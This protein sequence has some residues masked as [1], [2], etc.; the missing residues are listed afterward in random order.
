MNA[1][2]LGNKRRL[3]LNTPQKM[4][5]TMKSYADCLDRSVQRAER[6]LKITGG[7]NFSAQFSP[8]IEL[9]WK[10]DNA[11]ISLAYIDA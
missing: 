5:Q 2:C 8:N 10:V 9:V 6:T 3:E 4:K 7:L 11:L 1:D